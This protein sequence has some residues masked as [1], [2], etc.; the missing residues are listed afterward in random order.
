MTW[1]TPPAELVYALRVS[2]ADL[3]PW[4]YAAME[5]DRYDEIVELR[6]IWNEERD[7]WRRQMTP[8]DGHGQ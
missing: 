8:G 3:R 6:T 7:F 2:V 1:P 5:A 4:E